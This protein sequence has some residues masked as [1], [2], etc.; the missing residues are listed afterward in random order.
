MSYAAPMPHSPSSAIHTTTSSS[1]HMAS[2]PS[3]SYSNIRLPS[4]ISYAM[5]KNGIM[6]SDTFLKQN[7]E[8]Y[9]MVNPPSTTSTSDNLLNINNINLFSEEDQIRTRAQKK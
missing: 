7:V 6:N 9:E 1:V 4:D 5:I 2:T 8:I 3:V